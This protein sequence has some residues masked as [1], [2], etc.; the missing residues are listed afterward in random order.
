MIVALKWGREANGISA[1]R[2]IEMTTL[3]A[4]LAVTLALCSCTRN[5]GGN[6][7]SSS[8]EKVDLSCESSS[9]SKEIEYGSFE[10]EGQTYKTITI[11][12]QTW[13][14]ENL[15][16]RVKESMCYGDYYCSSNL[17]GC[18]ACEV[19]G[20]KCYWY[21]DN[22]DYAI[23]SSAEA[24]ANCGKYGRLYDWITAMDLDLICGSINC[25][26][27]ISAKHKGVCPSG[28]HIP[29]QAEWNALSS[30]VEAD[31]ECNNCDAKHLKAVCGWDSGGNGLDAYGFAA[32]PGGGTANG[33]L[34][35]IG[36]YGYW[37]S[38]TEYDDN[39]TYFSFM[40]YG[41]EAIHRDYYYKRRTKF[42]VR[43]VMD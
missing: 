30:Y 43:C 39:S 28:W 34:G 13:M 5:D 14:A 41:S 37:W 9:N 2:S 33:S 15:N 40:F 8:S 10:Y 1:G 17:H 4:M 21:G 24:Q 6:G 29:T 35:S 22:K 19:A 36:Y 3:I 31:K 42:S 23:I 26:D 20:T 32:L 7:D 11:G 38:A 25:A 16:Y 12:T 18:P 27:Q